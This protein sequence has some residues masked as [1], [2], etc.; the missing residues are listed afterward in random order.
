MGVWT[1]LQGMEMGSCSHSN[2][3]Y[4]AHKSTVCFASPRRLV[5]AE[6]CGVHGAFTIETNVWLSSLFTQRREPSTDN[7]VSH[8]VMVT[9]NIQRST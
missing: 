9:P 7:I 8:Y 4:L 1:R 2:D 5:P 3:I 6:S